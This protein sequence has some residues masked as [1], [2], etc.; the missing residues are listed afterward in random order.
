MQALYRI[1]FSNNFYEVTP[2]ALYRSGEMSPIELKKVLDTY[3]I[4]SVLD[5]RISGETI[6]QDGVSEEQ[7]VTAHGAKYINFP[8]ATTRVPPKEDLLRLDTI[9]H[10][11]RTPV[12]IHCSTG[13]LRTGVVTTL[14]LQEING[15]SAEL[16]GKQLSTYFGYSMVEYYYKSWA[17]RHPPL[18]FILYEYW[19]NQE[20]ESAFKNFHAW[21]QAGSTVLDEG[22]KFTFQAKGA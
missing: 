17:N 19:H 16:A 2:G 4:A 20:H 10:N 6:R 7:V 14:W 22:G 13:A 15:V 1:Q 12:L 18:P 11:L 3:K 21:L 5:L 8:L 9:L